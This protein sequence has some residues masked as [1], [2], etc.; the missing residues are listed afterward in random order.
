MPTK[1]ELA[2]EL[3]EQ[4]LIE[5]FLGCSLL[6]TIAA[7]AAAN[8]WLKSDFAVRLIE[9]D[10]ELLSRLAKNSFNCLSFDKFS[11]LLVEFGRALEELKGRKNSRCWLPLELAETTRLLDDKKVSNWFGMANCC[12]LAFGCCWFW[13]ARYESR[14]FG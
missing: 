8:C 5:I 14:N 2:P 7:A 9:A 6:I 3:L 13:L 12:W 1:F 11:L 4:C 10:E